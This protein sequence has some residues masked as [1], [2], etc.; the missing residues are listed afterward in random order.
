MENSSQITNIQHNN[1]DIYVVSTNVALLEPQI[2]GSQ[3]WRNCV[4]KSIFCNGCPLEILQNKELPPQNAHHKSQ[5]L[6]LACP[7]C[8][9]IP[10]NSNGKL[11]T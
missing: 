2:S 10:L 7:N 5:I 9:K 8:D 11:S 6:I 4:L 3:D 1:G